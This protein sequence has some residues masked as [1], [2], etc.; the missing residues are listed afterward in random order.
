MME[1]TAGYLVI[2]L[3]E[4]G[5]RFRPS[6]W[7]ERIASGF[8]SFDGD[9]RL[10]YNPLIMPVRHDGLYA[11]F[12]ADKLASIDPAGHRFV[13]D[14]ANSCQLQTKRIGETEQDQAHSVLPNVA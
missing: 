1:N 7:V 11:L 2:G 5:N 12:V 10:R 8:A 9:Q 6:D 4:N 13:M 3:T 14:F